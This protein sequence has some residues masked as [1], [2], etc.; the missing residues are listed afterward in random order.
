MLKPGFVFTIQCR[1]LQGPRNKQDYEGFFEWQRANTD[2]KRHGSLR[3]KVPNL[4]ALHPKRFFLEERA[5][6]L[7]PAGQQ[8]QN[9]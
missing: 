9:T 8:S 7:P 3:T 1:R 6:S 4:G 5:R 2:Y